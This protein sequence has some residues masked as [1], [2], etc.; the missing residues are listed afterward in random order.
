MISERS[1]DNDPV[2][3]DFKPEAINPEVAEN[4]RAFKKLRPTMQV[5]IV[6]PLL[7][8][9]C[10]RY[11]PDTDIQTTVT[12]A[13][14]T[15]TYLVPSATISPA[16]TEEVLPTEEA[17]PLPWIERM[18]E[19][20]TKEDAM[21]VDKAD[22]TS[23]EEENDFEP[24]VVISAIESHRGALR[25]Q[26]LQTNDYDFSLYAQDNDW[27]VIVEEI[28]TDKM[29]W[30][31]NPDGSLN[32]RPDTMPYDEEKG[33]VLFDEFDLSPIPS[34]QH[35][36]SRSIVIKNGE[37]FVFYKNEQ[38]ERT[39][40]FN[41]ETGKIERW[42]DTLYLAGA[43]AL[44]RV[45]G[46][47]YEKVAENS[48]MAFDAEGNILAKLE[49][50]RDK[51]FYTEKGLEVITPEEEELK[52]FFDEHVDPRK[53][54][55]TENIY[56]Y[57][58]G[59]IRIPQNFNVVASDS[60]IQ[61]SFPDKELVVD[62]VSQGDVYTL[63]P[64]IAKW[65]GA[66]NGEKFYPLYLKVGVEGFSRL[67]LAPGV[68][69]DLDL[70]SPEIIDR[71]IAGGIYEV[72]IFLACVREG[73]PGESDRSLQDFFKRLGKTYPGVCQMADLFGGESETSIL[74]HIKNGED[75]SNNIIGPAVSL[76]KK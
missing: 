10:D 61:A 65:K 18:N 29:L 30:S 14:A 28:K 12:Q 41:P 15:E 2:I 59:F 26:G 51:W 23:F 60:F 5:A 46:V 8:S 52:A 43:E 1:H 75:I 62:E 56:L 38:G 6:L 7:A 24:M 32:F 37:V 20:N 76:L 63:L 45:Q 4:L 55:T 74:R 11:I 57:D 19:A 27:A 22:W 73:V 39:A 66:G 54:T 21:L 25:D 53:Y 72:G 50:G 58:P 67:A 35:G 69:R 71:G 36:E 40:V 9:A 17:I 70:N 64:V 44:A 33:L 13:K 42:K 68:Y 48:W 49:E 3:G 16:N 47:R 31:T 34:G